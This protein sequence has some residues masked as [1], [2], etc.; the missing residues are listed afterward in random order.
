MSHAHFSVAQFV[1]AHP[2]I[3]MRVTHTHGSS[4]HRK[5]FAHVSLI[6]PSRFLPSHVSLFFFAVLARSLRDHS[7]LRPLRLHQPS[8]PHDLAVLSRPKSAG[9]APLRTC[10]VKFSSWPSSVSLQVMSPRS[11]TRSLPWIMTRCSSTIRT[12]ISPTSRKPRTRTLDNLVFP[13]CLNPL[14]PT[15]LMMI[16]ALQVESK[17]SM[18]SGNRC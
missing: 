12:T 8:H 11:S 5:V 15:V 16:F 6:S 7:R 3:F 10:I 17:E 4:V 18:Q 9:H 1:C 2:D 14:F 13:Q